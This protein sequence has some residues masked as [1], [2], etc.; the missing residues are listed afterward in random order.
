MRIYPD[1]GVQIPEV[2]LPKKGTDL[3]KWAVIACD[4]FTS[5]PEYWRQVEDLVGDSPSTYNL[6][7]P[8]VHLEAEDVAERIAHTQ[9]S[10]HA[11]LNDG[12]FTSTEGMILIERSVAG[13]TRHGGFPC[14]TRFRGASALRWAR[15]GCASSSLSFK[16]S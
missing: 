14:V 10:M 9:A 6:I 1:I 5:Q 8:E 7:L 13:R 12:L 16:P 15:R 2:L 11:Y 3:K 4:Q